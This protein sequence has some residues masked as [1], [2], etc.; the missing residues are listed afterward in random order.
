MPRVAPIFFALAVPAWLGASEPVLATFNREIQPLLENHCYECHGDGKSKGGITLDG[1]ETEA[2]LRDHKLWLRVLKNTRSHIMPPADVDS[3]EETDIEKLATWIKRDA[4]QLDP[5]NPD[6]GRVT[7][8]RLN[9]IEYRNTVRDLLGAKFDTL[10]EFPADDTGHGFDNMA[11]VLT[12]SP[13]LL[14][15]YLDAAQTIVSGVVPTQPRVVAEQPIPGFSFVTTRIESPV[16]LVADS[17][18]ASIESSKP[19]GVPAAT[20]ATPE[21]AP[22]PVFQRPA[23]S[24]DGNALDLSYYTPATV[25]SVQHIARSGRYQ[26]VADLAAVE[27]YVDDQF[28]YNRCRMVF[29][30]DGETVVDQ[31]F[32][33]EGENKA[34]KFT[35]D[36]EWKAGE[37]KLTFEIRPIGPDR[38]QKRLLRLRLHQVAVRGP[39][40]E[41]Y[42]VQ[43]KNYGKY[44]PKP[45]PLQAAARERYARELLTDFV[46]RAFR[47]PADQATVD[48][49][50]RMAQRLCLARRKQVDERATHRIFAV[51][52]NC[53][54]ALVAKRVQLF[55][56]CLAINPFAFGNA[57][58]ELAD[59]ERRQHPL[60]S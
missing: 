12:I 42:W 9:R 6:P 43:P 26:V 19:A 27:K 47:R 45:V 24:R 1:C 22:A 59:P 34:Y 38:D 51:F 21:V 48:R 54:G 41:R 37:H 23:P 13:M 16:T 8:R 44:F 32:V 49:L 55:D 53:V 20:A 57:A 58:G 10:A 33:R 29:T 30:I 50:V 17:G 7:V 40:D 15:K 5:A 3:L 39:F 4:F 36:R 25:E 18:P 11:D 35:F 46:T 14:E 56:E 31:E 28:D 60:R 2:Q 52:C